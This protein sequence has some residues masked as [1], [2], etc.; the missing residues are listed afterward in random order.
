MDYC[1]TRRVGTSLSTIGRGRVVCISSVKARGLD[2]GCNRGEL[3]FTR[4]TSRT[5]GG[6]GL[7]VLA[8]GLAVSRL[9]RGCKREAVSQLETVAGAILFDNRDL[10][11]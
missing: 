7:L 11:G 4:L 6:K 9:E 8:A 3:T 5:R 10:E 1:S 2:I